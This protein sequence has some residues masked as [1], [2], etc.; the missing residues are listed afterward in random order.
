MYVCMRMCIYIYIYTYIT[1]GLQTPAGRP[2]S[3]FEILIQ[4]QYIYI[5]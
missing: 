4:I 1:S 2:D 3:E 5:Y